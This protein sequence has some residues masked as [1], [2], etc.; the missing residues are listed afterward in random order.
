M[1]EEQRRTFVQFLILVVAMIA[2]PLG[3]SK[4]EASSGTPAPARH[5]VTAT[6]RPD[7]AADTHAGGPPGGGDAV[8]GDGSAG[9]TAPPPAGQGGAVAADRADWG[10]VQV[11]ALYA[12]QTRPKR[13]VINMAADAFCV[14]AHAKKVGTQRW[15]VSKKMQVANVVVFVKDGV[16]GRYDPPETAAKLDQKGCVYL[17][18]V[19]S[20]MVGQPLVIV[21]SDSTLHNVHSFSTRQRPFNFAQ[22]KPGS[23]KPVRFTR[24]EFVKLKCDVH[25]WMNAWIAVFD[26]PFHGV[27]DRNGACALDL[28][29]GEYTIGAWHEVAGQ[30]D[31]QTV[32][33]RPRGTAKLTVKL[34]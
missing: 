17:P 8:A 11:T 29:P 1:A 16:N 34:P 2:V 26:H 20:M 19:Q 32:Q 10:R 14:G 12:G 4:D 30:L 3:C 23:S 25:P 22:P 21:N 6:P 9:E 15:R 18:H 27:T 13:T 33:V 7:A 24:P 31:T 5:D 28:P